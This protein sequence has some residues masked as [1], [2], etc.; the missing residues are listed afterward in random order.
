[1]VESAAQQ[2]AKKFA[3]QNGPMHSVFE[4]LDPKSIFEV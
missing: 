2:F 1:M 4:F 3:S